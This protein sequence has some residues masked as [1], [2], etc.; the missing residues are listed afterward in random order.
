V[1]ALGGLAPSGY[2]VRTGQGEDTPL[3]HHMRRRGTRARYRGMVKNTFDACRV[4]AVENLLAI[5]RGLRA[6]AAAAA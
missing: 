5:D 1:R 3:A 6:Q 4:A 2:P